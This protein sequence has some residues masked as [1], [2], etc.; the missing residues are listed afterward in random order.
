MRADTTWTRARRTVAGRRR[1]L[2][3]AAVT[4]AGWAAVALA[5]CGGGKNEQSG[6]SA[7]GGGQAARTGSA[8]STGTGNLNATL[9]SGIGSDAGSMDPQS[10]AGTGGGN[11]PNYSTHFITP[12]TIDRDTSEVRPYAVDWKWVDNNTG[13]LLTVK[14]GVKFHNGEMLTAEQLK[15]NFERELGRAEYNPQFKSGHASQFTAVGDLTVVDENNLRIAL[16]ETDVILP[17]RIASTLFLVPKDYVSKV[18]DTDFAAKPV[19]SGPFKFVSR[20]PDSEI[21]S[22]RF[23]EFFYPRDGQYTPRL[24]FIKSLTQ[25]VIPE[26]TARSAALENGEIDLA[27][28]MSADVAKSFDGRSGFKVFYLPGDQPMHIHINTVI[29]R[30]PSSGQPNPWRDVRV[31]KAA[32]MAVDLDTIIKT[33]LTGKEQLSFGSA[34]Q[35]IGFPQDIKSQ[36]FKYDPQ[37]AKQ[38]LQQAGYPDGFETPFSYPIGRWPNTEQVVQAVAGYLS[39][40]G[41]KSKIQAKQYQVVTT[42]FKTH[43]NYGLTFWGMSG[44]PDPGANFRYGYHSTGAYTLSYDP[45]LGLDALIEQSEKE[46]DTDKRKQLIGEIITKFYQNASWIFLY[47]PVTVVIASDKVEW[48]PYAKVLSNPEYWNIKVKSS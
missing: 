32:N 27:H 48:T 22:E 31:R 20:T 21:R 37:G 35:S 45:A 42:E 12:L 34:Q 1:F 18:G 47:E 26:D 29:E 39:K 3:G 17:T 2:R 15:F 5:A 25:R 28:N 33:I 6:G 38:L 10:L 13:L 36:R 11:W 40:V 9:R 23:D 24:P 8:T 43:G 46:F 7:A 30:D 14:P 41:I 16:K 19:G 44:G 4:G